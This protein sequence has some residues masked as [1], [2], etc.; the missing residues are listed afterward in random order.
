M[1]R[2]NYGYLNLHYLKTDNFMVDLETV[3]VERDSPIFQ[4]GIAYSPR[5]TDEIFQA[6]AFVK[7]DM[8]K[9]S[10]STLKWGATQKAWTE[11]LEKAKY[12]G[13]DTIDAGV[14]MCLKR[15]RKKLTDEHAVSF[16]ACLKPRP[17]NTVEWWANAPTFDLAMLRH[18]MKNVPWSFW[19]ERCYRTM[20]A[21]HGEPLSFGTVAHDAGVDAERQLE[22]LIQMF[23]L[24]EYN[25]Y[26]H[27]G[28]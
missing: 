1:G 21:L 25:R 24:D 10:P 17:A 3:G 4:V 27:F 2:K 14:A 19:Q 26:E 9:A 15:V 6:S 5:G 18:Q 11:A 20:K 12:K 22:N 16:N 8:D 28:G 23:Y 7:P 13:A